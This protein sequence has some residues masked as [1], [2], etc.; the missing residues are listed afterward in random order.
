MAIAARFGARLVISA[1]GWDPIASSASSLDILDDHWMPIGC[2]LAGG[3]RPEVVCF[4]TELALASEDVQM[5][6]P[7]MLRGFRAGS[8]IAPNDVFGMG[9]NMVDFPPGGCLEGFGFRWKISYSKLA[10][11]WTSQNPHRGGSGKCH[12]TR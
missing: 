6:G 11:Q 9:K 10:S 2:P 1:S 7:E 4:L 12:V 5:G 8:R 3:L